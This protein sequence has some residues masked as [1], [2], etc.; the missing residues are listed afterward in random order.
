MFSFVDGMPS[1]GYG[2]ERMSIPPRG[3]GRSAAVKKT[4]AKSSPPVKSKVVPPADVKA[5]EASVILPHSAALMA[6]GDEVLRGE[7]GNTNAA[8]LADRLFN[9]GLD[10]REQRVVAD[11]QDAMQRSLEELTRRAAVVIVTGGL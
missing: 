5:A 4:A 9:A 6:I 11:E 2:T 3:K 1:H 8:F 7:I 10:V